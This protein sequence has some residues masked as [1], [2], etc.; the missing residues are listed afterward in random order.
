MGL[1]VMTV[2]GSVFAS[3]DDQDPAI[4]SARI[5]PG[6]VLST[7]KRTLSREAVDFSG[8]LLTKRT[9]TVDALLR[10]YKDAENHNQEKFL[11]AVIMG[12]VENLTSRGSDKIWV[13]ARLASFLLGNRLLPATHGWFCD[14]VEIL[15]YLRKP[16]TASDRSPQSFISKLAE[17]FE[18]GA[19]A[20]AT[21]YCNFNEFA[22]MQ[23]SYD[24]S[25]IFGD[26]S[27][28]IMPST[29]DIFNEAVASAWQEFGYKFFQVYTAPQRRGSEA[30][31]DTAGTFDSAQFNALAIAMEADNFSAGF[32]SA[33]SAYS[34]PDM[35]Q[36]YKAA[37]K[38]TQRIML[39]SLVDETARFLDKTDLR[40]TNFTV[41]KESYLVV[42]RLIGFLLSNR[43]LPPVHGWLDILDLAD[44]T[45]EDH[46][47]RLGYL[48]HPKTG[49]IPTFLKLATEPT[50][51]FSSLHSDFIA[52]LN[53]IACTFK[54]GTK[55]LS[56]K[57]MGYKNFAQAQRDAD[58][59]KIFG[60]QRVMPN[61]TLL[62]YASVQN[63][64]LGA[65]VDN[66]GSRSQEL[67]RLVSLEEERPASS[68]S[69]ADSTTSLLGK[70]K[71]N[72]D[73]CC[74]GMCVIS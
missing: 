41:K 34:L 35:L 3:F 17:R 11:T 26:V 22:L 44:I 49:M 37:N 2:G 54:A 58:H 60:E 65:H 47:S 32:F 31:T 6:A 24:S 38:S 25:R 52:K 56:D 63:R 28:R 19:K 68:S 18:A 40:S 62:F 14:D 64:T 43:L 67:N 48:M 39:K 51:D 74:F 23:Y 70:G 45:M 33:S 66:A 15:A 42:A 50:L 30:S 46:V 36:Q 57:R 13:T 29:I 16:E 20:F 71:D 21:T 61:S 4:T 12:A 72:S 59:P 10:E 73:D 9:K 7:L 27:Q 55:R 1:L 5:A 69:S 8:E 53:V